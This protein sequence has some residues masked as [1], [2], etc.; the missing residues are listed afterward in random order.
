MDDSFEI[1]SQCPEEVSAHKV[2]LSH[3]THRD[4]G[5]VMMMPGAS[6]TYLHDIRTS[7]YSTSR[8]LYI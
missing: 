2:V 8:R 1:K 3:L 7:L 4:M 5:N 6:V